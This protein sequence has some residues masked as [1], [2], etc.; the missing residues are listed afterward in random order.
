MADS[1]VKLTLEELEGGRA[2][3]EVNKAIDQIA[4]DVI[5]RPY[6]ADAREV[7]VKIKMVPDMSTGQNMPETGWKVGTSVP[8]VT[9]SKITGMVKETA[10]GEVQVQ[11]NTW[12]ADPRQPALPGVDTGLPG[13]V[14]AFSA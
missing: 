9:G 10:D 13:N 11:V 5:A 7:T 14:K 8:G 3:D 12:S 2:L 1:L 4:A 6:I